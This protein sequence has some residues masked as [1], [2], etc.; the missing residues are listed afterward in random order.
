[1]PFLLGKGDDDSI[2]GVHLLIVRP[3]NDRL[4]AAKPSWKRPVLREHGDIR[5]TTAGSAGPNGDCGSRRT[6]LGKP[7]CVG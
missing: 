2:E 1:M 3:E 5:L 4:R 6:Q 7:P